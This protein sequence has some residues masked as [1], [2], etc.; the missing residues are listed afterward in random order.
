MNKDARHFVLTGLLLFLVGLGCCLSGCGPSTSERSAQNAAPVPIS[1]RKK[2]YWIQPLKGHPVHQLTQLAFKEGCKKA[3]YECEIVGTDGQDIAGTI[4]LAEQCLARDD[5]AGL[6]IWAAN[7]AYNSF[8]EKA[9]KAGVPVVL[10]HFP[11]PEGSIPGASCIISCDPAEYAREIA[12]R[13][14]QLAGGKGTVAITQGA[15]IPNEN[16]VAE[17]LTRTLVTKH[18]EMKVLK[19][20]EEGFDAPGAIAKAVSL[21]QGNPGIVAAV[22]TTGGGPVAWANARRETGRDL[23]VV[24][25]D[26]TRANLDLVKNGAVYAVVGQP[27]WEESFGAAELLARAARGERLSWWIKLP[28]PLI[29]KDKLTSYYELVDKVEAAI[30]R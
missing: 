1:A 11:A 21:L 23:I 28:A 10:P 24:G 6:A 26:Y 29:T 30:K 17:T 25:M 16:L 27:L 18:P 9:G 12:D 19:P 14:G 13:I 5:A 3:G 8:I 2:L 20:I 15:F 7:P 4:A 22:S